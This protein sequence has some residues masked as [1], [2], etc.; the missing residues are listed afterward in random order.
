[1]FINKEILAIIP[2][3]GGSKSLPRKN[4]KLLGDKPLI[5]YTI[6]E[7]LRSEY[8]DR[9]ILSTDDTE[10][11]KV[12]KDHGAEVPFL[13]PEG[14]AKDSSSSLSVILHALEYFKKEEKYS[15]DIVV[16]LQP[17]SP[18]R[19]AEHIDEGI[20]KIEDC[21][22]VAG[23]CEVKEH[24]HFMM[25]AEGG[26]LKP[27][28]KI[29]NRP[30]R[31]QDVPKLYVLNAS[32]YIAKR[33]Y[34]DGAK[35]LDPVAPIFEGKVTGVFMDEISSIDIDTPLDFMLAES[36]LKDNKNEK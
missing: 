19:G 14:L 27:Y 28:L 36:V 7:A 12:A 3:R 11:A 31:R 25:Q 23:V 9:V 18:F 22:A 30:H 5:A 26:I 4:I 17:T 29:K 35:D 1:M 21:D 24:P 33:G 34:Y 20:E 16:F 2:A 32:L 10:I 13:R 6:E 8:I 15:P